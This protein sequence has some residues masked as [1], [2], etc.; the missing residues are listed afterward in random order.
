MP[1][2]YRV[3]MSDI[4]EWSTAPARSGTGYVVDT[5]S[6]TGKAS[7]AKKPSIRQLKNN[8]PSRVEIG[9]LKNVNWGAG[10]I[11]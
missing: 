8:S 10:G 1:K 7:T 2:P 3:L 11:T 6:K 5:M 9:K 4:Q